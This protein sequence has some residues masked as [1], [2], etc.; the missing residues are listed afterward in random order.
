MRRIASRARRGDTIIEVMFAIAVFSLVA[1]ISINLM[2]SGISTTESSIEQTLAR[3]EIDAQAAALR[4]IHNGYIAEY[5]YPE[6]NNY[7]PI[8]NQI[9]ARAIESSDFM[10][11]QDV[12]RCEDIYTSAAFQR[13]NPFVINTRRLSGSA[14]ITEETNLVNALITPDATPFEPSSLNPRVIFTGGGNSDGKI[15]EDGEYRDVARVEGIWVTTVKGDVFQPT[16]V[17]KYYDFYIRTCWVAPGRDFPTKLGSIIRLYNP[18][19][20]Y[21]IG[22]T[23]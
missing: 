19:G 2:N 3:A 5:E 16:G 11:T 13:N 8:W 12:G 20:E 1:V 23:L 6:Y 15:K 10:S 4:F 21:Q 9:T 22:G 14:D 18:Q 17:P 7:V